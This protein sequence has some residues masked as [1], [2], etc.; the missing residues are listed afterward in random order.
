MKLLVD[1]NNYFL[2]NFFSRAINA[3]SSNPEF[4]LWKFITIDHIIQYIWKFKAKE[5][6]LAVDSSNS[7]RKLLYPNYKWSRAVGRETSEVDWAQFFKVYHE[8]LDEIKTSLPFKV[9]RIDGCEADDVIASL[10]KGQS[11]IISSD[12]DF[13]QLISKNV[14]VFN[15]HTQKKAE[16]IDNFLEIAC[17]NGQRKDDIPNII[18]PLDWDVTSKERRPIFGEKKAQKIINE[19][20]ETWLKSNNLEQ[21]YKIQKALIDLNSLPKAIESRIQKAYNEYSMP[22]ADN[23]GKFFMKYEWRA[24]ME[25]LSE[26]ENR[27]IQLY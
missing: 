26:T 6:I 13:N 22:E 4:E 7:W 17:L 15:P 19:G 20:L 8:Y 9:L 27:L 1:S 25:K 3:A 11:T 18:T 14:Q 23:I 12:S 5:V 21:R 10:A 2:R 24:Y 16:K